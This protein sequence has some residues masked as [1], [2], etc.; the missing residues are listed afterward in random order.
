M[1]A[2]EAGAEL[3]ADT[4]IVT[5]PGGCHLYFRAPAGLALRNTAGTLGAGL[6]RDEGYYQVTHRGPIAE[7]PD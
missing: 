2:A 1:L 7:L 5:T 3:P 4:H 6:R